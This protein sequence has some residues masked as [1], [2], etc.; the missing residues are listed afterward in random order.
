MTQDWFWYAVGA[1]VLYGLHQVFTKMAADKIGDGIGGFIVEGSAAATIG[2]YL[3]Y[4]WASRRWH[5]P[6]SAPGIFY[7][8]LTGLCVGVG[9]ILF[10]LLFQKG[11]PLS[12]LPMILAAG[13]ALM[14]IAGIA[15][16]KESVS[17]QRGL[18]VVLSIAGL[19]LMKYSKS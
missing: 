14:A 3:I 13:A 19:F 8:T 16:F 15:F 7:S 12:A 2:L 1:A 18:G 4:L 9:T 6:I 10:F 17:W 11:G 5:Q